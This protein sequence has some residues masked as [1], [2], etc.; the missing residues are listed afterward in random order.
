MIRNTGLQSANI[1]ISYAEK[2]GGNFR[3]K[4]EFE[5]YFSYI[6]YLHNCIYKH[7]LSVFYE[8]GKIYIDLY[9]KIGDR[10]FDNLSSL[11]FSCIK[12]DPENVS[13]IRFFANFLVINTV[14]KNRIFYKFKP[15]FNICKQIQPIDY[16]LWADSLSLLSKTNDIIECLEK[17]NKISIVD[18]YCIA[19]VYLK[20]GLKTNNPVFINRAKNDFC[21]ISRNIEFSN[22][23]IDFIDFILTNNKK[24][25]PKLNVHFTDDRYY[26]PEF[27]Y[28]SVLEKLFNQKKYISC[29]L[30]KVPAN[31]SGSFHNKKIA[32]IL[33]QIHKYEYDHRHLKQFRYLTTSATYKNNRIITGKFVQLI[34]KI[35]KKLDFIRIL[36]DENENEILELILGYIGI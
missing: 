25:L 10:F 13:F 3:L 2:S 33:K 27:V 24:I 15:T 5:P 4:N 26:I 31:I 34:K 20:L 21:T 8:L 9:H 36:F 18:R 30:I 11:F 7:R 32:K 16:I 12:K 23:L 28:F 29:L 1:L 19:N 17:A 22:V 6:N 14:Y 35:R